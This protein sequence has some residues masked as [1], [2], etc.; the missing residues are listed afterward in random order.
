M[1][2]A[3]IPLLIFRAR[4]S[5]ELP[6]GLQYFVMQRLH[7]DFLIGGEHEVCAK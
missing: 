3:Q 4:L 5:P 1:Y 7:G 6:K 2:I